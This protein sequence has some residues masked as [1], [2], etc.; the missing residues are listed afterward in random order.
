MFPGPVPTRSPTGPVQSHEGGSGA[1]TP[2]HGR[3][4]HMALTG[5]AGGSLPRT[6]GLDADH[7]GL[8]EPGTTGRDRSHHRVMKY[9]ENPPHPGAHAPSSHVPLCLTIRKGRGGKTRPPSVFRRPLPLP[10]YGP[11][12]AVHGTLVETGSAAHPVHPM[13]MP[14]LPVPGGAVGSGL[15]GPC[16]SG[17]DSPTPEALAHP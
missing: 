12:S 13:A 14:R 10:P 9:A 16:D 8:G 1:G 5:C 17:V 4:T 2:A 11:V 6:C 7:G 15:P 3:I